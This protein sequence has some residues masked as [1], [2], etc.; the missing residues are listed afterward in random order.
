MSIYFDC[1]AAKKIVLDFQLMK[2][3]FES[4]FSSSH[5]F[6]GITFEVEKISSD[7]HTQ[8]I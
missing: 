1:H 8:G 7:E 4:L 2:I 5:S 6:R 3:I